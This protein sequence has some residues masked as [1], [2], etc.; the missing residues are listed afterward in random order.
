MGGTRPFHCIT[1]LV[2]GGICGRYLK[3]SSIYSKAELAAAA[4]IFFDHSW[5]DLIPDD[6]TGNFDIIYD[7]L[8]DNW[9]IAK[10]VALGTVI[11]EGL[12]FLLALIVRAANSPVEYDSDDEYIAPR[13]SV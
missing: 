7:F 6:K 10:W 1:Y 9:K 4:F 8:D 11:L 13:S 12:A 2:C 5:K 3:L